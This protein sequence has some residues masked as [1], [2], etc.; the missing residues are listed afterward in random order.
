MPSHRAFSLVMSAF[1]LYWL[2]ACG[3]SGGPPVPVQVTLAGTPPS[4]LVIGA[5]QSLSAIVSNDR[6]NKGVMWSVTCSVAGTGGCGSFS[7]TTTASGAVTTYTAPLRVSAS[8]VPANVRVAA[9]SIAD[10]TQSASAVIGV[11]IPNLSLAFTKSAYP[12]NALQAGKTAQIAATIS[13]DPTNQGLIWSCIPVNACGSF[14]ATNTASGVSTTYTAPVNI[15]YS[16][17]SPVVMIAATSVAVGGDSVSAPIFISKEATT[18]ADGTYV[19]S[20]QGPDN[21]SPSMTLGA[22]QL[23]PYFVCGAFTV[24]SGAI[25][26]GEEDL[27]EHD[28]QYSSGPKQ[29]GIVGGSYY[30][31]D[32]GNF[33]ITLN[34]S[35][36]SIGYKGSEIL[37]AAPLSGSEF[38]LMEYDAAH[39]AGGTLELQT[40]Q[41]PPSAAYAFYHCCPN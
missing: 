39:M 17:A 13:G 23:G 1:G 22:Y 29:I 24:S 26:G 16:P 2:V 3:G 11:N 36:S 7:A 14:S 21:I 19:F 9:T 41:A 28:L 30:V 4:S 6:S 18:L 15:P 27:N 5:T 32:G 34:L 20:L 35:N 33:F 25:V 31:T 37:D 8:G 38:Q 40:S 12:P 10:P